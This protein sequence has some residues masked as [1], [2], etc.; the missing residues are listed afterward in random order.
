MER[1]TL[2]ERMGEQSDDANPVR[3]GFGGATYGFDIAAAQGDRRQCAGRVS[4]MDSGLL[5]VFHHPADVHLGAV[6]QRVDVDLNRVL[7][8]PIDQNGM[9]R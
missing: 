5:D 7:K 2:R 4:G 8:E 3:E 6:A 9:I 1:D